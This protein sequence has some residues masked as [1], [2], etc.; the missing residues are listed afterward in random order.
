MIQPDQPS[1][2]K[3]DAAMRAALRCG[4]WTMIAPATMLVPARLNLGE[5]SMGNVREELEQSLEER[6]QEG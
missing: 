2:R 6:K 3:G 1:G 5:L 4:A